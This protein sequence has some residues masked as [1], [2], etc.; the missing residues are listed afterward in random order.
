MTTR[1]RLILGAATMA[2]TL[3]RARAEAPELTDDGLYRQ[4]WFIDSFLELGDDLDA[5]RGRGKRLAVMWELKGC[6]YCKETHFVNFA[7]GDIAAFVRANFDI[8]Q[9]NIIGSRKVTDF[10]GAELTEKQIAAKYAVRFTPT[11]QFFP[12]SA[13]GL[14][15]IAADKREVAR[16]AGYYRPDDFLDMFRYVREKAYE[17]RTFREFLKAVRS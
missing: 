11:F 5:A 8:L 4:S 3:G 2:A 13:A 15:E 1:R 17:T 9:L 14:G 6:P 12:D 7:R 16:M 10:D